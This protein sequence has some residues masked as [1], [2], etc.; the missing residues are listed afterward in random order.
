MTDDTSGWR[1]RFSTGTKQNNFDYESL[2][3]VENSEQYAVAGAEDKK[4]NYVGHVAYSPDFDCNVYQSKRKKEHILKS[5]DGIALSKDIHEEITED[6]DVEYVFIGFR[7][8]KD[9]LIF[10]VEDFKHDWNNNNY[11][12]QVYAKLDDAVDKI[13]NGLD[14]IF[15]NRPA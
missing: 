13:E 10:A 6:H 1:N 11:D 2:S 5:V 9:I 7:R 14:F 8:T 3:A 4:T 15:S 12:Q